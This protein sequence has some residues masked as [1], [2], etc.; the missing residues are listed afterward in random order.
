MRGLRAAAD[1]L[2]S[3]AADGLLLQEAEAPPA[4]PE[5]KG[6]L[7]GS[8]FFRGPSSA[9]QAELGAWGK[10]CEAAARLPGCG[11]LH[12]LLSTPSVH[13]SYPV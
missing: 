4:P 5:K 13:A 12:T 10:A 3:P 6:L 2:R 8:P 1:T 9:E 7:G 11:P